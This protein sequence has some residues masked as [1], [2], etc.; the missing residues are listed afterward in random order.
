[1][2]YLIL[3]LTLLSF[4]ASATLF[5]LVS[6]DFQYLPEFGSSKWIGTYQSTFGNYFTLYFD[7]Y[8]PPVIN[9]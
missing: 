8:C 1:M 9:C 6:C 2:K 3:L 4:E 5:T 7:S